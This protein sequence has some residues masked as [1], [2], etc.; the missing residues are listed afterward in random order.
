MN[1]FKSSMFLCS[2]KVKTIML[3]DSYKLKTVFVQAQAKLDPADEWVIKWL[4]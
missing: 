2:Y 1:A 3:V 4:S